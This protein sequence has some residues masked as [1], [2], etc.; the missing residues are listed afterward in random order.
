MSTITRG[1]ALIGQGRHQEAIEQIRQG[2]AAHQ[3]T[4]T[5]LIRPQF[6]AMLAE[7]LGEANQVEEALQVLNEAM[8]MAERNRERYYQAELRRLQGELLCMKP[9][10]RVVSRAVGR[11]TNFGE[12]EFSAAAEA[13]ACFQESIRIAREQKAKSLELRA[14]MSLVR[15]HHDQG[16]PE[17]SRDLLAQIY[18]KFTQGF[19]TAD[20]REAKALLDELS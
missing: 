15:L 11:S 9:A 5:E 4:G 6:L 16:R 10:L 19:E 13:E 14:A 2:L 18:N 3:A 1:W 17:T 20:L 8:A 7:A 12:P